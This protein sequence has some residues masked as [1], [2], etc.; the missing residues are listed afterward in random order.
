MKSRPKTQCIHPDAIS[1]RLVLEASE[2]KAAEEAE[3]PP[4]KP[5][6]NVK[7]K[8]VAPP[9]PDLPDPAVASRL[10]EMLRSGKRLACVWSGLTIRNRD[11]IR[12]AIGSRSGG[13]PHL[14]NMVPINPHIRCLQG[15]ALAAKTLLERSRER[16]IEWWQAAYLESSFHHRFYE[17][18]GQVLIPG[19][20]CGIGYDDEPDLERVFEAFKERHRILRQS[21]GLT[22][23]SPYMKRA[24]VDKGGFRPP[25]Y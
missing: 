8:R 20:V 7:P 4:R 21:Q 16:I 12:Y 11:Q 25:D 22:G 13:L 17:E 3:R 5:P 2:Q 23:W 10:L 1:L 9:P 24:R 14:W 15:D 18:V 6:K 19:L